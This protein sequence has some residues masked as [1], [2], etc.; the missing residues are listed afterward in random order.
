MPLDLNAPDATPRP[1][2]F[3]SFHEAAMGA[4]FRMTANFATVWAVVEQHT[5]VQLHACK[6][7]REMEELEYQ[8]WRRFI[9]NQLKEYPGDILSG[10]LIVRESGL[11]FC[12]DE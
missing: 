6:P 3:G 4:L 5:V 8:V 7:P 1:D 2:A 10:K 12:P 11:W 9:L